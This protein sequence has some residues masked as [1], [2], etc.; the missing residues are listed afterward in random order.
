MLRGRFAGEI[1][2]G[3]AS[4]EF[5]RTYRHVDDVGI[6][7][8]QGAQRQI[9]SL[10]QRVDGAVDQHDLETDAGVIDLEVRKDGAEEFGGDRGGA[11]DA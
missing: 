3:A 2:R 7:D 11:L 1:A 5:I 6:G 8:R 10:L 9:E 4:H